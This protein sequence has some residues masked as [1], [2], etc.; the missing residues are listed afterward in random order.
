MV[1]YL[2]PIIETSQFICNTNELT[3]FYTEAALTVCT[4]AA[5]YAKVIHMERQHLMH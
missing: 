2:R 3:G 5:F 4:E 1:S